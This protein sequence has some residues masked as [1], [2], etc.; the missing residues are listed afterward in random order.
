MKP[1]ALIV[2]AAAAYA[3][4]AA[5]HAQTPQQ[6]PACSAAQISLTTDD[7]GGSL[8]TTGHAGTLIVLRNHGPA[9]CSVLPKP[10]FA[11]SDEAGNPLALTWAVPP[12][13]H[14]GPVQVPVVIPAGAEVTAAMHWTT[15]ELSAQNTC[16]DPISVSLKLDGGEPKGSLTA[17][18]C[19]PAGKPVTYMLES[20]HRDPPYKP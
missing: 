6:V 16:V 14:P 15:G 12:G 11:F 17:H 9:A 18:I 13:M 10:Q 19:G 20:L 3:L 4:A 8:N 1:L 5:A 2:P 7:L